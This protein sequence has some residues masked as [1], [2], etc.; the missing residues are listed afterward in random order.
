MKSALCHKPGTK[1]DG[2]QMVV[3]YGR[4]SAQKDHKLIVQEVGSDRVIQEV[5]ISKPLID[6]R[7]LTL[8]SDEIVCVLTENELHIYK[9]T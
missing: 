1:Q 6:I 5:N 7:V 8:N 3:L 9:W 4:G 2:G